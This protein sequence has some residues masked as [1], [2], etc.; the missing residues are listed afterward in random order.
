MSEGNETLPVILGVPM[1]GES[2]DGRVFDGHAEVGIFP[3]DLPADPADAFS[4]G[5]E[6]AKDRA[7]VR[8]RPPLVTTTPG[9]TGTLPHI[10]LDRAI[11]FLIGDK[12]T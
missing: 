6:R 8:F 7:F 3:G 2:V 10:R 1:A 9:T 12:L 5:N 4:A 11:E